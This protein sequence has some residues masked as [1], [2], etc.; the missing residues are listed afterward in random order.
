MDSHG[1]HLTFEF[2]DICKE[3]NIIPFL[4]P[5]HSTHLLQPLDIGIFQGYKH[6]HQESLEKHVRFSRIDFDKV[7]FLALLDG[8]RKATFKSSTIMSSFQ[9]AGLIPFQPEVV[10]EKM[11]EFNPPE[12]MTPSR[13]PEFDFTECCTP[14][15]NSALI[16]RYSKY[17]DLRIQRGISGEQVVSP[18]LA[19]VIEKRDKARRIAN[20][21][22]K[23]AKNELHQRHEADKDK[24]RRRLGNKQVQKYGVIS[25]GDGRLRTANR[26]E[27]EDEYKIKCEAKNAESQALKALKEKQEALKVKLKP[28]MDMIGL[29]VYIWGVENQEHKEFYKDKKGKKRSFKI[30]TQIKNRLLK[31]LIQ[32]QTEKI[33]LKPTQKMEP[34]QYKFWYLQGGSE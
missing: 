33:E 22:G 6:Y 16:N 24:A 23:L 21:N 26:N 15:N 12:P 14:T 11:K 34:R 31:V 9:K 5:P 7:E 27:E 10:Y 32:L 28:I 20:I 19:R 30:E 29:Q 13:N 25:L 2:M 1:S 4:L 18:T 17:I 8:I 3:A